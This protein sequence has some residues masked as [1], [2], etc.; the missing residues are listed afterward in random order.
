MESSDCAAA[1]DPSIYFGRGIDELRRFLAAAQARGELALLIATMGNVNDNSPRRLG[2][3]A[4]A[5][6]SLPGV[7]E[8]ISGAR[9][10]AEQRSRSQ[11]I[12]RAPIGIWRCV[13]ATGAVRMH[14]GGAWR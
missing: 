11:R 13:C 3:T 5:S 12:C 1:P 14:P 7:E 8:S 6:I 10:P 2:A 4:D 9:L